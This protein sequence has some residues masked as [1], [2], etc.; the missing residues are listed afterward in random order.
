M[1]QKSNVRKTWVSA[2][3]LMKKRPIIIM[4]FFFIA[5]LE[6]LALEIIL[7][8]TRKPLSLIA[9][10][11][12]RKFYG[13]A[14]AHYPYNILALPKLFYYAQVLIYI[15]AGV[16]LTAVSINILK[17][18]I[19]G[20]PIRRSALIHN[21][22][23]RY[24][25]FMAAGIIY[26]ALMFLIEKADLFLSL[27]IARIAA[28]YMPQV[29]ANFGQLVIVLFLFFTNFIMQ[30]FMISI[31]PI[32]VI[33]KQPLLKSIWHS[34]AFGFRNFLSLAKLMFLPFLVYLPVMLLKN[35]SVALGSK[36]FPEIISY[37]LIGGIILTAFVDS[38][39]IICVS[40]FLMEKKQISD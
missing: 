26:I 5:F 24:F 4:P 14:F 29:V 6:C 3:E 27:K 17:S 9:G 30:I 32:M 2:F 40:M 35:Y 20:L 16:F 21:A 15:F 31:V 19:A 18:A 8:S 10:P 34:I 25:S 1:T 33:L 39:V 22:S 28:K 7:F 36:T 37:I 12:M 38:F 13:E 11:I 23:K